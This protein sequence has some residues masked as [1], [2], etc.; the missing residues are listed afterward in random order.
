VRS[1]LI[2]D[3]N[4]ALSSNKTTACTAITKFISDVQTNTAPQGPITFGVLDSL[5]QRSNPDR[6]GA[7]LLP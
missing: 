2:S 4:N 1:T 7:R 6:G 3:L 5:D